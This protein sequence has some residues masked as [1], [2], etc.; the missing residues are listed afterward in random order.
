MIY[1]DIAASVQ[2]GEKYSNHHFIYLLH[3]DFGCLEND[4]SYL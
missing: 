1:D 3:K 2:E 4:I